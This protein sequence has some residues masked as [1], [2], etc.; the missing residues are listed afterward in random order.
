MKKNFSKITPPYGYL[1]ATKR[2]SLLTAEEEKKLFKELKKKNKN[3]EAIREKI[4]CANLRLVINIA[5]KYSS[6]GLP[7]SDLIEEGNLGLIKAIEKYDYKKG[8][9]FS[10]Y[11]SWWIKQSVIRAIFTQGR[12]IKVPVYLMEK[13][14]K[15]RKTGNQLIQKLGR[16][17]SKKEIIQEAKITL[18]DIKQIE[19]ILPRPLSLE[20]P[21]EEKDGGL[22]YL[23]DFIHN[24]KADSPAILVDRLIQRERIDCFLTKLSERENKVIRM[25][26]GLDDGVFCTLSE[27]G[28]EIGLT[29]ER[30]RQIELRALEKL[31]KIIKKEGGLKNETDKI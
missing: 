21:F 4:I 1:N 25:R 7:V 8:F 3:N 23:I 5:R 2:I 18:E 11:A 10:T 20:A 15:Y 16:E 19:Q 27:I 31:K 29:R 9:K 6:L 12:L 13:I 26:F 28:A 17:P 30:V 22:T 14:N 24:K